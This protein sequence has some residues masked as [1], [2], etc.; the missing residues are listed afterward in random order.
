M[1]ILIY[2]IITIVAVPFLLPL[3][4][5][6]MLF[7]ANYRNG[8]GS[9]V[10]ILPPEI[11]KDMDGGNR[12]WFH[13][14]SVGEVMAAAPL[15]KIFKERHP[16]S[17]IIFST[18]TSTGNQTARDQLPEIDHLIY[19]PFD[20]IWIMRKTVRIMRPRLFI[21]FET[22]IWPNLLTYL[23]IKGIPSVMVNGR[24]SDRSFKRY[25]LAR[26]VLKGA[27]DCVTLFSMQTDEDRAKI[28][29]LGADPYRVFNTGNIKYDR[30]LELIRR[31][32]KGRLTRKD[33]NI[34]DES[35][36]IVAGSTH[37]GE[38]ETLIHVFKQILADFPDT[39]MIIAPRHLD[40]V[41]KIESLIVS[42]G[43]PYLRRSDNILSALRANSG[44]VIILDT[45]GEL[46][47]LYKI[48][49]VAFVG[50]SLVP[51]GGHNILEPAAHGKP[52][53]F[54]P[55]MDNF[56]EISRLM[57]ERG[58]AIKANGR[59]DL[60]MKLHNLLSNRDSLERMGRE[61][62]RFV[63]ENSGAAEK[64]MRLIER[65]VNY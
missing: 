20:L 47:D 32:G 33:L 11:K 49:T 18:V 27:L 13:A 60:Y 26:L 41:A 9:R 28:V 62:K 4:L 54:G 10:G 16:N 21:F 22:E 64:N 30:A 37:Q 58:G 5:Y 43:L 14:V 57:V 6:R 23:K 61:A 65:F 19:F 24:I 50:G 36:V 63:M 35:I 17:T 12:Y 42:S 29:S 44:S 45:I 59:D 8:V 1:A 40:R 52:V 7:D 3:F 34:S 48:T 39:V 53:I 38:E 56:R 55:H 25:K 31:K 15:I 51:V 2:N 46:S